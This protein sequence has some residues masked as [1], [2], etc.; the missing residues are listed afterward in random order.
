MKIISFM[1][2]CERCV[3]PRVASRIDQSRLAHIRAVNNSFEALVRGNYSRV[4][5]ALTPALKAQTNPAKYCQSLSLLREAFLSL[6]R[7][8]QRNLAAAVALHDIGYLKDL[9]VKHGELGGQMVGSFLMQCG[10]QGVDRQAVADIVRF[11]GFLPDIFAQFL[12]QQLEPFNRIRK[13][14]FLL[15][16]VADTIGKPMGNVLSQKGLEILL[17]WGTL[18]A[19]F[20][21][22]AKLSGEIRGYEAPNAIVV[23]YRE[24]NK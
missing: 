13:T 17:V 11:H 10:I 18:F 1:R 20:H 8:E 19:G 9:G 22:L 2:A 6:P 15:I 16:S 5:D 4:Y 3:L 21:S 14:Q 23:D 24:A 12:P 7:K